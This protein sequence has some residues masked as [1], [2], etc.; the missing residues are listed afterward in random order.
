M[1]LNC[2]YR[3]YH[4]ISSDISLKLD[5]LGYIFVA[6]CLRISSITFTQ[7]APEATK[8]G[9]ITQNK[10]HLAVQDHSRSPILVPIEISYTISY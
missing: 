6:E 10:G 9:E 1:I 3:V 7:C 2:R 8:F 5:A 4:I